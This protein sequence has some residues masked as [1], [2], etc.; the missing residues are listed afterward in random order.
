[1]GCGCGGGG[2]S[3]G[4]WTVYKADGTVAK[5]FTATTETEAQVYANQ[6]KGTYRKTS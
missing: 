5:Q 4:N 6:I 3:L 1:M 2:T